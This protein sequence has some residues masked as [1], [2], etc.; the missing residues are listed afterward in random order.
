MPTSFYLLASI[1]LVALATICGWRALKLVRRY[2]GERLRLSAKELMQLQSEESRWRFY[3]HALTIFCLLPA[4]LQLFLSFAQL[5]GFA[6]KAIGVS[7]VATGV[8][9]ALKVFAKVKFSKLFGSPIGWINQ[10]ALLSIGFAMGTLLAVL[11]AI[12]IDPSLRTGFIDA[13]RK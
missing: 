1:T 6:T 10:I 3:T 7:A 8:L 2:E 13:I 11:L 4:P 9:A 5:T 12:L